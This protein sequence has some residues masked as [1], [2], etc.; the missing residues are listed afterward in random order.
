MR[1][2]FS[3]QFVSNLCHFL[4]VKNHVSH[5]SK[6]TDEIDALY[7]FIF[8]VWK[9][10]GMLSV[11]ELNNKNFQNLLF[12]LFRCEHHFSLLVLWCCSQVFKF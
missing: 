2:Y 1:K 3:E 7:I 4:R 12:L 10:D 9:V 11:F 8:S 6:T 5:L